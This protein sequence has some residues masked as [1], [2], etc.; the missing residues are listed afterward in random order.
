MYVLVAYVPE[1]HIEQ[2]KTAIFRAG[3]GA[4]GNY[5]SCS[6]QVKGQGQFEP[7]AGSEPYLGK[8]DRLEKVDEY[9]LELVCSDEK[10]AAVAEALRNSHPYEEPAYHFIKA[11]EF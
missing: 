1:T 6:W 11:A 10:A 3:G 4:I 2:V 7:G 5:T 9:R 8:V